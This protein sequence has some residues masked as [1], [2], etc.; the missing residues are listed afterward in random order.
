ME[1]QEEVVALLERAAAHEQEAHDSFQR[2]DTDGFLS[3][4]ASGIT[5]QACRLEAQL[6]EQDGM[7][8][9]L[10]LFDL[11]GNWVPAKLINAKYGECWALLDEDGQFT[12]EFVGAYPK[13]R[14]TIANKGYL[15]GRVL[16]PAGVG[17]SGSSTNVR[18]CFY[19]KTKA[20]EAPA[21]I[22]TSDRWEKED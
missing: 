19:P 5:A 20:H 13:Q 15:E 14:K 4:W 21:G 11:E 10:A 12:G 6:V 1:K 2:C 22:I 8:S 16:R 7:A 18:A 3:Q 9:F 17:Y